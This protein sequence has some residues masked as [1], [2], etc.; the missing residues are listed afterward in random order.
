MNDDGV[1]DEVVMALSDSFLIYN[2]DNSDT[3]DPNEE[4]SKQFAFDFGE[5]LPAES[6]RKD[7]YV[8]VYAL[9]MDGEVSTMDNIV[10]CGY[11]KS[12]DYQLND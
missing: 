6:A 8:A 7:Y 4:I 11:G 9:R 3:L 1:Y 10:T 12:V 5:N 2:K